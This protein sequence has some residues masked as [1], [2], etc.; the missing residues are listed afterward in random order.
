MDTGRDPAGV[1]VAGVIERP[2][3]ASVLLLWWSFRAADVPDSV[4]AVAVLW[5][6]SSLAALVALLFAWLW[7]RLEARDDRPRRSLSQP[8]SSSAS[9]SFSLRSNIDRNSLRLRLALGADR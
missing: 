4:C 3:M 7:A 5:W 6:L 9:L 2:L 1:Q 8:S